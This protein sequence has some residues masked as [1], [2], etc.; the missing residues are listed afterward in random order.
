M[1]FSSRFKNKLREMS[2][3]RTKHTSALI[4][5]LETQRKDAMRALETLRDAELGRFGSRRRRQLSRCSR[6]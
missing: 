3:L 5:V 2:E 6:C 4:E 1:A